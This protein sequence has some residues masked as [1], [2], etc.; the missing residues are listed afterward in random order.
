VEQLGAACQVVDLTGVRV[1]VTARAFANYLECTEHRHPA[2]DL[3][4]SVRPFLA[5]AGLPANSSHHLVDGVSDEQTLVG[6]GLERCAKAN[7]KEQNSRQAQLSQLVLQPLERTRHAKPFK[8]W[9]ANEL[10]L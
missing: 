3:A 8:K 7:V 6:R 5:R 1:F 2:P 4:P 10:C 9:R